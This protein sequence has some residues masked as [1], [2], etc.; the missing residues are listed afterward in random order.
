MRTG[1]C[2]QKQIW[3]SGEDN[4]LIFWFFVW[5]IKTK[6][7]LAAVWFLYR[8]VSK[9]TCNVLVLFSNCRI[10][11]LLEATS[12]NFCT[13]LRKIFIFSYIF[14]FLSISWYN[15]SFD[16]FWHIPCRD[17]DSTILTYLCFDLQPKVRPVY[18]VL[19]WYMMIVD[20]EI[21]ILIISHI[22]NT[23]QLCL[24]WY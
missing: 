5:I 6:N 2:K 22:S 7:D 9:D 14:L 11:L 4:F 24:L 20:I 12:K 8:K 15:C 17:L 19:Y 23:V 18:E 10:F 13:T 3:R 16:M 21:D 1:I